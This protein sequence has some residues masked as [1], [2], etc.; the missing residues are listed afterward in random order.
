M[1]IREGALAV[2]TIL[3]V[4][5]SNQVYAMSDKLE[6]ACRC[7]ESVKNCKASYISE[8]DINRRLLYLA[9]A[10]EVITGKQ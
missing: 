3:I 2:V 6:T 10:Y 1:P 5:D 8:N 9:K 4:T 7:L